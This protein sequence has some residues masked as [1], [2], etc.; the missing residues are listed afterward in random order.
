MAPRE[1]GDPNSDIEPWCT[2]L[3]LR[4]EHPHSLVVKGAGGTGVLAVSLG[5]VR[6]V[7]TLGAGVVC[8]FT[9]A[10]TLLSQ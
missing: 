10:A 5:T 3:T 1:L 4:L 8:Q 7:V 6:T 9:H 2:W